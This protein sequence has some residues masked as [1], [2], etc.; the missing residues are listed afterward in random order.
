MFIRRLLPAW[1]Q[2][3][4]STHAS[5]NRE[6]SSPLSAQY[7]LTE[8]E[9]GTL[10][11]LEAQ[12]KTT[13][14]QKDAALNETATSS[15]S[16]IAKPVETP[17]TPSEKSQPTLTLEIPSLTLTS[18]IKLDLDEE[19]ES[20]T[21]TTPLLPS[22]PR[23]PSSPIS[24][25]QQLSRYSYFT[26]VVYGALW[27]SAGIV[28]KNLPVLFQLSGATVMS[29]ISV[30]LMLTQ[31]S[32]S[33]PS[34]NREQAQKKMLFNAIGSALATNSLGL[35]IGG[36]TGIWAAPLLMLG[37]KALA[38]TVESQ[39]T[40]AMP[41]LAANLSSWWNRKLNS[42]GESKKFDLDTKDSQRPSFSV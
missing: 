1:I 35:L 36:T 24:S 25:Y 8:T 34:L 30:Q 22:K 27:D 2:P 6:T 29:A 17:L 12:T 40:R 3:T 11:E 13:E 38:P 21:D 37:A 9:D 18:S 5:Q 15:S 16:S 33:Y 32:Y 28:V 39:L 4:T 10:I 26:G 41:Q 14:S 20:D 23:P 42:D 31:A 19:P 7:R